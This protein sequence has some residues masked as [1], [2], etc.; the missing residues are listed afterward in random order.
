MQHATLV[1]IQPD[2][3]RLPAVLPEDDRGPPD[4]G[5]DLLHLLRPVPF[6]EGPSQ[7]V[8]VKGQRPRRQLVAG[9][10][11]VGHGHDAI[12]LGGAD[13]LVGGPHAGADDRAGEGAAEA[14]AV[15]AHRAAGPVRLVQARLRGELEVAV[16]GLDVGAERRQVHVHAEAPRPRLLEHPQHGEEPSRRVAAAE[17]RLRG[18]E[19][20]ALVLEEEG[21]DLRRGHRLDR[22]EDRAAVRAALH[23]VDDLDVRL[24]GSQVHGFLHVEVRRP[25]HAGRLAA[26]RGDGHGLQLPQ[27]GLGGPYAT[28]R[29]GG[30]AIL[31]AEDEGHGAFCPDAAGRSPVEDE[32]SACTRHEPSG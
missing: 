22:V 4:A 9:V 18:R 3:E 26:A 19:V 27:A 28:W 17:R 29:Q 6:A 10:R 20:Q 23:A 25:R 21:E 16:L 30:V 1:A 24:L 8:G 14:E 11:P 7:L 5:P 12:G 15:D 31:L 32:R 2:L 13:V